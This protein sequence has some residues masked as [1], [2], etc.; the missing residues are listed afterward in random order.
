VRS[1]DAGEVCYNTAGSYYCAGCDVGGAEKMEGQAGTILSHL[2]QN[3]GVEYP[4]Y[5]Q[6]EWYIKVQV[7]YHVEL[8]IHEYAVRILNAWLDNNAYP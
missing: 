8:T 3:Q 4:N 6:K 2:G 1:L 5:L 7:G